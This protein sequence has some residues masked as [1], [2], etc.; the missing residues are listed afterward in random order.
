MWFG[1]RL[2]RAGIGAVFLFFAFRLV[3]GQ[4]PLVASGFD[5]FYNLEYQEAIA[6]FEKAIAQ[7][8]SNPDYHN[9]LAQSL[10]FQEMFRRRGNSGM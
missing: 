1:C 10:L 7:D 4:T 2:H 9:H 5:H 6:D 3:A 8:P